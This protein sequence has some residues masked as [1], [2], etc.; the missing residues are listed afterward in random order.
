MTK[1]KESRE[2]EYSP[3]F[4]IFPLMMRKY[5]AKR[6]RSCQLL[7]WNTERLPNSR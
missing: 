6:M 4:M 1:E 5:R 7:A 2:I 3:D